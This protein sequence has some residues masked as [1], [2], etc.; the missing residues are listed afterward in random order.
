MDKALFRAYVKELVKEQIEES[1]E[2]A[3]K[4]IL[5]EVLNEAITEI[6][7]SQPVQ[8]SETT[9]ST[10]SKLS[11][12]QLAEIMGLERHGDTIIATTDKIMPN[13]PKGMSEDNPAVQAI[14][15]DYS[16]VMKAMGLSK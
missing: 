10:K 2:K 6:K 1:V 5:P 11:R 16:Q 14:N 15:R 8:V 13:L 12:S 3:V 4:K 7:K 9:A